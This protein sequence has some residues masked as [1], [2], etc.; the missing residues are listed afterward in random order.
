M[1]NDLKQLVDQILDAESRI[2]DEKA[3][4]GDLYKQAKSKGYDAKVLRKVV[5]LI[6]RGDLGKVQ[7]E[8]ALVNVYLGNLGQGEL[9]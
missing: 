8:L 2:A 4:V 7:E 5:A 6:Q 3:F 9:F 1:G